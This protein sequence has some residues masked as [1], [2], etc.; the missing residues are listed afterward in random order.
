MSI[1]PSAK[2]QQIILAAD[3][4]GATTLGKKMSTARTSPFTLDPKNPTNWKMNDLDHVKQGLDQLVAKEWDAV[5]GT[6]TPL[7]RAYSELR[8]KLIGE[9]DSAT[10]NHQ[11]G[12]SLYKRAR[13]A[14]SGPSSIM[15]AA[16]RGR[17][18]ITKDAMSI[19]DMTNGMSASELQAFRIGAFES[20][21]NKLGR[22]G[23]QT[24]I[25]KMWKEP[26]TRERLTAVFGSQGRFREFA[27]DVAAEARLKGVES[28]GRGSATAARAAGM[29]NLDES[30]I[31]DAAAAMGA[32]KSGNVLGIGS[33]ISNGWNRVSTPQT[34]RDQMGK[35]L[36]TRGAEGRNVLGSMDGLVERI[37]L[38]N[39]TYARGVGLLGTSIGSLVSR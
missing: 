26:A 6:M 32:A 21:R 17:Q 9:L 7:G 35:M 19:S 33:A 22:E 37:N 39:A 38:E 15:D 18:S 31:M 14:Y 11:T 28:V 3:D 1:E 5:A 24:E 34:V 27:A 12:I 23:G 20:L 25:L 13:D 30:A 29:G 4:L 36:M 16:Q 8:T 10:T 2:I